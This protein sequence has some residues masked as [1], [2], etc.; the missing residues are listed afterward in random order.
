MWQ[1]GLAARSAKPTCGWHDAI[2]VY[3][4]GGVS[5]LAIAFGKVSG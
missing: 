2:D 3:R 4:C 1:V 5:T